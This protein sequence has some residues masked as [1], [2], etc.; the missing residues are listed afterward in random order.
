MKCPH[1]NRSCSV[2]AGQS[3]VDATPNPNDGEITL[4]FQFEGICSREQCRSTIKTASAEVPMRELLDEQSA[5]VVA[6]VQAQHNAAMV[7][8]SDEDRADFSLDAQEDSSEQFA[9][10]VDSNAGKRWKNGKQRRAKFVSGFRIE[11]EIRVMCGCGA[12]KAEQ[13]VSVMYEIEASEMEEA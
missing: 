13:T 6:K 1:C 3:R 10:S 11:A 4:N 12:C 7:G 8:K 9:A 2:V 5:D